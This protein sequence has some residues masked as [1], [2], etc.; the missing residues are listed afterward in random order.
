[1]TELTK[2]RLLKNK[3][4]CNRTLI[5]IPMK[6]A[7]RTLDILRGALW[8]PVDIFSDYDLGLAV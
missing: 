4:V 7:T 8:H 2:V 1:M 3:E 6:H 5:S